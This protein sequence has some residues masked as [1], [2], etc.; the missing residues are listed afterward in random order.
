MG[1]VWGGAVKSRLDV[2]MRPAGQHYTY[3]KL[4]IIDLIPNSNFIM[5]L[6]NLKIWPAPGKRHI[7]IYI[8]ADS[9]RKDATGFPED[10]LNRPV[11]Q[12]NCSPFSARPLSSQT[13]I[14]R[15][16]GHFLL[17]SHFVLIF[18]ITEKGRTADTSSLSPISK[19]KRY[20]APSDV[21]EVG[22]SP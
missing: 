3:C 18:S 10:S 17:S 6:K 12:L 5:L 2:G 1:R 16:L 11:R 4:M 22:R 15:F 13:F 19:I 9:S 20:G 8:S 21:E 14:N 7:Y